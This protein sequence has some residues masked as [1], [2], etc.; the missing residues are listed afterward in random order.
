MAFGA[1]ERSGI[2][3]A[4]V[5]QGGLWGR[6][7]RT[8]CAQSVNV[9]RAA[10]TIQPLL[11]AKTEFIRDGGRQGTRTPDILRVKQALYQLS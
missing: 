8:T 6:R 9:W 3:A 7:K 10:L 1:W 5:D 2:Y 11:A 4:K